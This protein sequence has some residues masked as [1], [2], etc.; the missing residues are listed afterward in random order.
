MVPF[1]TL[2]SCE[3]L[4]P[5]R[6]NFDRKKKASNFEI[7]LSEMCFLYAPMCSPIF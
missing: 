1:F 6:E 7:L 3:L 4:A 5:V 2:L